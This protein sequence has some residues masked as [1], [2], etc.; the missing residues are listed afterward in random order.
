MSEDA[1]ISSLKSL[2]NFVTPWALVFELLHFS[3]SLLKNG[4]KVQ[5]I[6]N[7]TGIFNSLLECRGFPEVSL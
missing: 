1:L 2:V 7:N 5:H 3:F 6:F 4:F